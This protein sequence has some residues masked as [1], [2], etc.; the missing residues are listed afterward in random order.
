MFSNYIK[1]ALRNLVKYKGYSFINIFGLAT[2]IA[3]CILIV[4]FVRHELRFDTFHENSDRL[5]QV[6]MSQK[7]SSGASN[8]SAVLPANTA[9]LIAPEFPGIE[10]AS[11]YIRTGFRLKLGEDQFRV[12]VG[13][14]DPDFLKM[15]SFNLLAGDAES[16]LNAPDKIVLTASVAQKI[17]KISPGQEADVLG[18]T[19]TVPGDDAQDFV[20]SAVV[21]DP[22]DIS[23]IS[24]EVLVSIK[25]YDSYGVSNNW[26]GPAT[27]YL[28]L[29]EGQDAA[30]LENSLAPFAKNLLGEKYADSPRLSSMGDFNEVVK[31]H[32]RPIEDIYLN[33]DTW[34]PYNHRGNAQASYILAAI[35]ALVLGIACI[36][37]TTLSIGKSAARALEVGM[38]KVLGAHRGQVMRQFWGEALIL[39]TFAMVLG[40]IMAWLFLPIF[41]ELAEKSLAFSIFES[42]DIVLVLFGMMF[43]TGIFAGSYPAMVLSRF[44]PVSVFKGEARL[45][46]RNRMTRLLVIL[47]YTLSIVLIIVTVVISQQLTY[48]N[49][50]PLGYE[51]DHLVIVNTPGETYSERYKERLRQLERVISAGGSDRSFTSGWQ[52]RTIQ[53]D[54][55]EYVSNIRLIRVDP[56]YLETMDIPLL[57]GRN[58]EYGRPADVREGVIVNETFVKLLGWENPV[59]RQVKGLKTQDDMEFPTVIGV[60]KDFHIDKLH[61]EIQ[62]LVLHMNPDQHG[63]YKLFIRIQPGNVSE[64]VDLLRDNWQATVPDVPFT[65]DFLDE[66]LRKQYRSEQR[67]QRIV[68]YAAIFAI[69]ISCLGLLGL[70]S[71]AVSRRTKELGIRKVLGASSA[72][73][74]GLLS[75]DFVIL[76]VLANIVAWPVAYLAAQQWLQ[77]FVYRIELGA[78]IFLLAGVLAILI[79][80]T[81]ISIQAIRASLAN[82]V[83]SL[84]Y[85]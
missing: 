55:G 47:Q 39:S 37:F 53:D 62:P 46:S 79:A 45:K 68:G 26:A 8:F 10:Y 23:S 66:N 38:R 72:S 75:K 22:S 29:S 20:V 67:W 9:E 57:Q 3:C 13:E 49:N 12:W 16:A 65:Y 42:W 31:F 30:A 2:G 1:I 58:F 18:K 78:W 44:Q 70:A 51:K 80:L 60:V 81:T 82:P 24:F 4:L 69:M 7:A 84:R 36:N 41:N 43:L 25:H 74:V 33:D 76:L 73:L 40:G 6:V 83:D 11:G 5:Y 48:M 85:E 21:E 56:D 15:F 59:S 63:I 50:K 52:T 34:T 32:L 14:T 54:D 28:Q 64:T 19:L 61:R 71:L 77:N 35:A 17:F 27:I